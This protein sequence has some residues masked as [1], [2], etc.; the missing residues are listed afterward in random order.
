MTR[1]D[2]STAGLS[3]DAAVELDR[4]C[5]AFESAWR[6]RCRPAIEPAVAALSDE[7]RAAA[8][9]ELIE[10]DVYY[11]RRSGEHAVPADYAGRFPDLDPAWLD[12]V[13]RPDAPVSATVSATGDSTS[14]DPGTLVGYFGDYELKGVVATGAMGVVYKA[15]QVSLDRVVALKMI[16]A[17]EFA[18]PAAVRRFK[19]EAEAAATLDHPHIVPIYEVG[20]HRSRHYYAM[21]LLEG[22]SLAARMADLAVASATTRGDARRRQAAVAALVATIARAVHHAHQRGI[23]H[24]DLKPANVLLDSAG[25]PLVADFGLARRT[26]ADSTLTATGAILGTPSYM[27]PEQARGSAEV[28]TQA[29]VWGLGA[30]LYELLT[31]QPPFKG[32][33]MLDTLAKVK[34]REPTRPRSVSPFVNHDLETVC[35][36]CLEKDPTRRYPS[37]VALAED[38]D[39]WQVSEPIL[40]RRAGP[41]ERA[42]K[43]VKRNPAGAGLAVAT[44]IAAATSIWS[45]VALLYNAELNESKR[46]VEVTN[47]ELIDANKIRDEALSKLSDKQAETDRMKI[48]AEQGMESAQ[49]LLYVARFRQAEHAWRDGQPGVACAL[50]FEDREAE[51]LNQYAGVEQLLSGVGKVR[52][53][54]IRVPWVKQK[55]PSSEPADPTRT[56]RSAEITPDGRLLAFV[57]PDGLVSWWDTETGKRRCGFEPFNGVLPSG[58]RMTDNCTFFLSGSGKGQIIRVYD[59]RGVHDPNPSFP[60]SLLEIAIPDGRPILKWEVSRDGTRVAAAC[61]DGTLRVWDVRSGERMDEI[62][63]FGEDPC[64][65]ALNFDG[66]RVIRGG[67]NPASW[68]LGNAKPDWSISV[69]EPASYWRALTLSRDRDEATVAIGDNVEVWDA[70]KGTYLRTICRQA[71]AVKELELSPDGRILLA[72]DAE[73]R[74]TLWDAWGRSLGSFVPDRA[75]LFRARLTA[76]G[77][78]FAAG[79]RDDPV[80]VTHLQFEP[81]KV[82][83]LLT[84]ESPQSVSLSPDGQRAVATLK[85]GSVEVWSVPDGRKLTTLQARTQNG[86][87]RAV[88]SP[89]GDA[90]AVGSGRDVVL[91]DPTNGHVLKTLQTTINGQGLSLSIYDVAFSPDGATVAAGTGSFVTVWDHKTGV[92]THKIPGPTSW[93]ICVRFSPDGRFLAAGSGAWDSDGTG[94][95]VGHVIVWD[96][97]T[98]REVFRSPGLPDGIY[99]LAWSP[100]GKRVAAGSGRYQFGGPGG[101]HVW[102]PS[103]GQLVFDLKGHTQCVWAVTFSP[104]GKR[105]ISV[106]G[107]WRSVYKDSPLVNGAGELRVWDMLTGLELL[108]VTPH[109]ATIYGAAFTSDGN[110]FATAGWDK[111]I[112][113]WNLKPDR[114]DL[115]ETA[116]RIRSGVSIRQNPFR[117]GESQ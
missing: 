101:V 111:V 20:E 39:R 105:L 72:S 82:S 44:T 65:F 5:D 64:P 15:R 75:P 81:T 71:G 38:L 17:G 37:A 89:S 84:T 90:V 93:M 63:E 69:R 35:L 96:L 58:I 33:D 51:R 2:A 61:G 31:G 47:S 48:R 104:D 100:D 11:R 32:T 56:I 113:V 53:Q 103:S 22:G 70:T 45:V 97:T 29:D 52:T 91:C 114:V 40:A 12:G 1:H 79:G 19:Q 94:K 24:R 66:T 27:A 92:V 110:W 78:K 88:F 26:D 10:L 4:V 9:R 6:S 7:V 34:D 68:R 28:T 85:N 3:V 102:E 77:V 86:Y 117:I 16:R 108:N 60:V 42:I 59:H 50:L 83:I 41:V 76:N 18:T 54:P 36:K 23:L 115:S 57:H 116:F 109:T 67:L 98:R 30:I 74:V 8:V 62:S 107:P 49:R 95:G 13:T 14:L 112:R 99:G 46:K 87:S 21:R 43:W 25:Q 73:R 80:D 55:Q 106:G